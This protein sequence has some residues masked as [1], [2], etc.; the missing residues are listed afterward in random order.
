MQWF[1]LLSASLLCFRLLSGVKKHFIFQHHDGKVSVR[2]NVVVTHQTSVR[3]LK[4]D[5]FPSQYTCLSSER[6]C[7]L[8]LSLSVCCRTACTLCWSTLPCTGRLCSG[9]RSSSTRWRATA[10]S[11]AHRAPVP[12]MA[13]R[14]APSLP[15]GPTRPLCGRSTSSLPASKRS[16]RQLRE[17]SYVMASMRQCGP[18]FRSSLMQRSW[19]MNPL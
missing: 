16:W 12:L 19:L 13:P 2:N 10:R 11:R 1:V 4:L 17:R 8:S 7:S 9:C 14:R 6:V 15:S 3:N 18:T 5:C